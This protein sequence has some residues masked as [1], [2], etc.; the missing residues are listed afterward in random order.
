MLRTVIAANPVLNLVDVDV[1]VE[2]VVV[3]DVDVHVNDDVYVHVNVQR[4]RKKPSQESRL[5]S[6]RISNSLAHSP[7]LH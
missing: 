6:Q 1:V 4:S 7:T 3:V 2:V 5:A